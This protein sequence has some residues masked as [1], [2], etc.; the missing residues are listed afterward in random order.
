MSKIRSQTNFGVTAP[1]PLFIL[2]DLLLFQSSVPLTDWTVGCLSH[3]SNPGFLSFPFFVAS[4]FFSF[5]AVSKLLTCRSS[6]ALG[7]HGFWRVHAFLVTL[8]S[9]AKNKDLL[10]H[11]WKNPQV[12]CK[13]CI[14]STQLSWLILGGRFPPSDC[15]YVFNIIN[16][17]FQ[18][19]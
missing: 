13:P 16:K 12:W 1:E 15:Q 2:S 5:L 3:R 6:V 14:S 17:C 8:N 10:F 18:Q 4:G 11:P 9:E 7:S 19:Y